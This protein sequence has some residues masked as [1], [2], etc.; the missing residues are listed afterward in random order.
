MY[1]LVFEL[2]A[3]SKV[4]FIDRSIDEE[5]LCCDGLK[6]IRKRC[7][8]K[9]VDHYNSIPSLNILIAKDSS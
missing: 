4:R 9:S 6:L 1:P 7:C 8:K 5:N 3:I 2:F